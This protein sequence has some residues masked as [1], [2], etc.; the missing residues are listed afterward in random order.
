ME[1]E[2]SPANLCGQVSVGRPISKASNGQNGNGHLDAICP[3]TENFRSP[4]HLSVALAG[5]GKSI[6]EGEKAKRGA[7]V[8]IY[9]DIFTRTGNS[10]FN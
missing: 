5:V 7:I 4:L 2:A 1:S 9:M 10:R 3:M 6:G 8:Y